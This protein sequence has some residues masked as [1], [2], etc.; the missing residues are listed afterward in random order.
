MRKLTAFFMALTALAV[1]ATAQSDQ[2]WPIEAGVRLDPAVRGRLKVRLQSGIPRGRHNEVLRSLGL[3]T[4]YA[5]LPWELSVTHKRGKGATNEP[6]AD[7]DNLQEILRLEE[8][9]LRSYVVTYQGEASPE[10]MVHMLRPGCSQLDICEPVYVGRIT[11]E[12]DDPLI[13]EQQ[14]LTTIRAFDAWD[15]EEGSDSVLIG[16]SDSGVYQE[17]E[18]LAASLFLRS[19][20]VPNNGLDDDGNGFVDDYHGYNFCT[21]DDGTAPGNTFNKSEGHGTGVAGICGATVNNGIGVAGVANKCKLVPMKTM[22]DNIPGIVYGYESIMYC[23]LNGIQVVNCS[24]GGLS[25]SC[26]NESIID[27][28]TARNV[29]V[30]A[31]AGNHGTSA[32]F[33][34]GAYV[35]VLNVGVSDPDDNV[36][37]MTGH[38]PTVDIMAPGQRTFTTSN[39][40]TYGGFCCTSGSSPIVAGVVG[41]VLSQRN[42]SGSPLY[43]AAEATA[44]VAS[45]V[46]VVD[47]ASIPENVD[48]RLLPKGRLDAV[49]ALQPASNEQRLEILEV[50]ATSTALD[51]RWAAGDTVSIEV[52]A[53]NDLSP[54]LFDR[55]T[56]DEVISTAPAAALSLNAPLEIS[57]G[58][59][60]ARNE[61]FFIPAVQ[62]VVQRDTDTTEYLSTTLHTQGEDEQQ[63]QLNVDIPLTPAPA[64]RTL[65]NN[66]L[67]LSV[68]DR[69]RIGNTDLAKGQGDGF[70]YGAFCGQLYEGG[71][72]VA[73]NG[74]VVDGVRGVR[75]TN[76]HFSPTK[77]FTRPEPLTSIVTDADAPDSMRLDVE[78]TQNV[79]LADADSGLFVIDVTV[80]NLSD[81]V[82]TDVSVGWFYDWDLGVQPVEN[83]TVLHE[84]AG[85]RAVQRVETPTAGEPY[86]LVASESHEW[87]AQA[88]SAGLD[89]T[90]TYGCI[91][92][93]TK[94]DFLYS[95]TQLQYDQQND[96]AVVSGMRFGTPI[97]PGME[98][99]FRHVIAVDQDL[100]R[101]QELLA[102]ALRSGTSD[103]PA[104]LG[105]VRPNPSSTHARVTVP[106][107]A[108]N[109]IHVSD[110][111]GRT[112]FSIEDPTGEVETITIDVSALASG[113]YQVRL[114]TSDGSVQT[115]PMMVLR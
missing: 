111:E 31:A 49:L 92:A 105:L 53:R 91:A 96:V 11:A 82:L 115:T 108:G 1:V 100:A 7:G 83:T 110:L 99:T 14:M 88:V 15:V 40:G 69:A 106:P 38:G 63:Q 85:R 51:T 90:T 46:A 76:D 8:P 93:Q 81:T 48:A 6:L 3:T 19:G 24:W 52:K 32:P 43:T 84:S 80:R 37:G 74:R 42:A 50:T 97:A 62:A 35:N 66:V 29:A 65:R 4:L 9:L 44:R 73:A 5:V 28:A 13:K 77:R 68:G 98:R 113:V 47:W 25:K 79:R 67:T 30:V 16:I 112:V 55:M 109:R 71:L 57:V 75:Q 56:V 94:M 102:T 23:A 33:Y 101:A 58:R 27:Y 39:D 20:E 64:F 87:D 103:Q 60:I 114:I 59:Q 86:V 12:P 104:T 41:L 72:M 18:D 2:L 78:I 34:P 107:A 21:P 10:K 45:N 17:H 95:G 70:T 26:I 61:I 36:V 22:P 89:N 54:F